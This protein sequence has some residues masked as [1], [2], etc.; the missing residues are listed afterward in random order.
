MQAAVQEAYEP[1]PGETLVE[2]LADCHELACLDHPGHKAGHVITSRFAMILP[3]L[4]FPGGMDPPKMFAHIPDCADPNS[5]LP[6][7]WADKLV[8]ATQIGHTWEG[9]YPMR[10]RMA[11]AISHGLIPGVRLQAADCLTD[12]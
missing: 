8:N 11:A 12:S 1:C 2:E 3:E 4:F 5:A 6:V 10:G 9:L 7:P